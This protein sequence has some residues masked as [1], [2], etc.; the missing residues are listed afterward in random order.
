MRYWRN[1]ELSVS[2]TQITMKHYAEVSYIEE[3]QSSFKSNKECEALDH[4]A[5]MVFKLLL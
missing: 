4:V 1:L 2:G 5:K 3:L